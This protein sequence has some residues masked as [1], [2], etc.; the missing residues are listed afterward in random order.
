MTLAPVLKTTDP[1]FAD[2]LTL[3]LA[4]GDDRDTSQIAESV[5]GIVD[6]VRYQGDAALV[7]LTAKFD[8]RPD[9]TADEI[10]VSAEAR[11]AALRDLDP[12]L[13]EA[14][15]RA[16]SR[17]K[18]FHG[19]QTQ[20]IATAEL[21]DGRGLQARLL[22]RPLARAGLYVPGGTAAYPSTVLM[23]AIPA[24]VA[25]VPE[26]VMVSPAPDG[27]VNPIVLAAAELAGVDRV[28]TV[29]G[30]QAVAALAFGTER[31]PRVD[32][33]VGPGNAWVAEAK[34]QLYGV[35]D[36]DSVAGP[37]E[38]LILA[39]ASATAEAVAWDLLAQAEHDTRAA[40]ILVT[41][42]EA[43]AVGVSEALD[44][45]IETVPRREACTRAIQDRGGVV[46]ARDEAEAFDLTNRYAP[47]HLGLAVADPEAALAKIDNAGAVF[48]GHHTPEALGDYNAGVN[49][50]LPT[51]GTARFASPLSVHDFIKRMSVL[52]VSPDTLAR[53]GPDATRLA[54]AEGLEAH[55]R[56]VEVR[57]N[58]GGES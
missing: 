3:M 24:K 46:L 18:A 11:Q 35:V 45:I 43:L 10:E 2:R 1:S 40:A 19:L 15:E 22:T 20:H 56:A 54:R 52:E 33:V 28:F 25:G 27:H 55:A 16:A 32:K 8:R 36:I 42:D 41:W 39:D 6:Q 9:L 51:S 21:D 53:I 50:V 38:V 49:H 29:G 23:N 7:R 30:A 17:I 14:L 12:E 4:R 57:L 34:R 5:R 44:R 58:D 47:E 48:L 26:V 31:V 37:S 13:R